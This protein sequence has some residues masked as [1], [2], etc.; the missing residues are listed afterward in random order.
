LIDKRSGESGSQADGRRERGDR[1]RRAA[2]VRA[3]E[4][5]SVAGLEAVS[6]GR[7]AADLGM[8]KSGVQAVFGTKEELQL[9]AVAAAS[10]IF[11]AHVVTPA[12][13]A[14]AGRRRLE[15]LV[16]SWLA[17]VNRRVLPGGCFLAA[18]VPEF[19]SRPG[20]VRDALTAARRSWLGLLETEVARAQAAGE[21]DDRVPPDLLA[22][23]VE[24]LLTMANTACNLEDR[25]D[26][27]RAVRALIDLRLA[28]SGA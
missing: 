22:F 7:I 24:A 8:S 25:P 3:A 10:E 21:V 19:D 28:P 14:P 17:Y 16:E 9:A 26:A 13:R 12:L 23:E 1:T 4:R 27:L 18:T 20:P 6:L 15:A 5:A 2:A 11:L